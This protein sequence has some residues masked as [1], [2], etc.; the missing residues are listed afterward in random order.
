MPTQPIK[1][2]PR[3]DVRR[4]GLGTLA[5]DIDPVEAITCGGEQS[6]LVAR[7]PR[8]I[9]LTADIRATD[10]L[11]DDVVSKIEAALEGRLSDDDLSSIIECLQDTSALSPDQILRLRIPM[12]K[13]EGLLL[14]VRAMGGVSAT[15]TPD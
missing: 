9:V 1:P 11:V 2:R 15:P 4:H 8:E 13:F 12:M 6:G 10:G 14:A 5:H 3:A 7:R